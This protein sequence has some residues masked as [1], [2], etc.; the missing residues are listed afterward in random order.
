[1]A[2]STGIL[3]QCLDGPIPAGIALLK[4]PNVLLK[5]GVARCASFELF[6]VSSLKFTVYVLRPKVIVDKKDLK[7][8]FLKQCLHSG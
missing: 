7:V 6:V 5:L 2:D 4:C 8:L 1:M 3:Q